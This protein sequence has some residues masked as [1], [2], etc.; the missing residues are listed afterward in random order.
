MNCYVCLDYTPSQSVTNIDEFVLKF[1]NL[2]YDLTMITQENFTTPLLKWYLQYQRDLPWRKTK[3]P[4][5]IWVSEIMLQQTRVEAVIPYY[6]RFLSIFPTISSLAHAKEE[7]LYKVWQ[8]LGYYR[9]VMNMHEGAN[10]IIKHYHGTFPT[11][12]KEIEKIK[13]IGDYTSSAIASICFGEKTPAVDGN[14]LRIFSRVFIYKENIL[15]TKAKK[16]CYQTLLP[17]VPTEAGI[18]NQA[19]MDLGATICIANGQ[20]KCQSCPLSPICQG[21][22]QTDILPYRMVKTKKKEL[23]YTILLLRNHD[24][25]V[26]QKRTEKG[27]LQNMYAFP[28]M[29]GH[30]PLQEVISYVE[31]NYGNISSLHQSFHEKHIFTHQIWNML[32]FVIDITPFDTI[33][34]W[35]IEDVALPTAFKKCYDHIPKE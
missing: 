23:D 17:L 32:V 20:P 18:F 13:G 8:G 35:H 26:L 24:Q 6:H 33:K 28:M 31:K 4:Y 7:E 15:D 16:I 25:Y 30:I 22:N 11:T 19:L 9:R 10:Q 34:T 14:L 27:V 2:W 3:D 1:C 29:E 12:K 21:K 5:S